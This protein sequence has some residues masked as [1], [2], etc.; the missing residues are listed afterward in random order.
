MKIA[1]L[2]DIHSNHI[3]LERCIEEAKKLGAEEF[4]FLGDYIG[5]MAYPEKTMECLEKLR[6][7]YPCTFIRG[8]K[9]N[10][11]IDHKNGKH[12]DWNWIDGTSGSGMLNYSFAHLSEEQI[13]EF[14]QM[15]IAMRLLPLRPMRACG[16]I[17]ITSIL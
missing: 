1:V 9:E 11:W 6:K 16:R 17:M 12:G 10:Y 2:A 15:P 7:E 13:T 5:E 3:A 8:N 14:E 4:L